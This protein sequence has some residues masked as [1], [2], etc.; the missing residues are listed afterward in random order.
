MHVLP[1]LRPAL[2]GALLTTA[3][4]L[5][6]A[7]Q[8]VGEPNERV[9]GLFASWD[10]PSSAG[11]ALGVYRDGAVIY[12]RG[13]GMA[14]LERAVPITPSSLFDLGSTSKQFTAASIVLL[15]QQEKLS[16]DD[17][18]RLH[19]PELPDYG[20]PITL[21]H[22]LN[23][24]SGLRD[25]INLLVLHGTDVDDVTTPDDALDL[26]V[27]QKAL[28]FA[29][30]SEYLYSN[31]GYFLLSL[32]VERVTGSNLREFV[33][34]QFLA[35]LKMS[36][37]QMLGRYD[38]VMPGRALAYSS[39]ADGSLRVDVSR[40]MQLGDG[41]MFST[42]EELLLWD[43]QFYAPSI[44][45]PELI[46]QL[47]TP[48]KLADGSE[49]DYALGLVT[50][51]YRGQRSVHHGGAWGGYRAQL[52]RFPEQHFSVALL[53]NLGEIDA[54]ALAYQVADIYLEDI[55]EPG[56][57]EAAE[58]EQ[59]PSATASQVESSP[60]TDLPR[61][62]R[63]V[64]AGHWRNAET[65]TVRSFVIDGDALYLVVRGS[66]RYAVQTRAD[67]GLELVDAPAQVN[68]KFEPE[69]ENAPR[70]L[71]W[72]QAGH[73]AQTLEKLPPVDLKPSAL[74]DFVGTYRSDEIDA[75]QRI[76]AGEQG[77]ILH[78]RRAEPLAL[79][80]IAPDEFASGAVSLRFLRDSQAAISGYTLDVGR[81]RELRFE[82][83]DA[84]SVAR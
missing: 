8:G 77:I 59:A 64:L 37:S 43:Q 83:Q 15:A 74:A 45:G 69:T 42:I 29:P 54:S 17:D 81:I 38:D 55:L 18:V 46:E 35:P 26:V 7:P 34:S 70:R 21:R 14:D 3:P 84:A 24:T 9:D 12:A 78:R 62:V 61:A 73:D 11:C 44:V 76:E 41:A 47:Q 32:V 57:K 53:C 5:S 33:Q 60:A 36:R 68:L 10:K 39:R 27:R 79:A 20:T 65:R 50:Q 51:D 2:I 19:L 66:L 48:G 4:T 75:S 31:T 30:G 23:H 28:N 56:S 58:P 13:Y 25:Y 82:R 22:M 40:W 16:L 1:F 6:A 52:M 67:G 71:R 80:A 63:K 72:T 49:L